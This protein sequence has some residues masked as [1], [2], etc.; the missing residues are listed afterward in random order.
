MKIIR[1]DEIAGKHISQYRSDFIMRKILMT[2]QPSHVGIMDLKENGLVGYHEATVPQVLIILEGEGWVRVGEEEKV[3]VTVG[4]VVLWEKGEG[5]V[6]TTDKG[7][8]A[9]VIESEGLDIGAF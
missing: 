2:K 3:K 9:V 7:M 8:K 4:D 5:H 6:T 1:L